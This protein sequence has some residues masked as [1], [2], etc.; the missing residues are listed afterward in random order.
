MR[1]EQ[2][3]T[4]QIVDATVETW[5]GYGK[6]MPTP[7]IHRAVEGM[8]QARKKAQTPS[9]DGGFQVVAE[10]AEAV[11]EAIRQEA[12]RELKGRNKK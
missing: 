4:I 3:L 7:L 5:G 1:G 10:A 9:P 11:M 2:C 6:T 12:R 8:I